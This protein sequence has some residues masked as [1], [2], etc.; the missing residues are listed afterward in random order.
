ME[1]VSGRLFSN[2]TGHKTIPFLRAV[3]AKPTRRPKDTE[4]EEFQQEYDIV[5]N[6]SRRNEATAPQ[7]EATTQPNEATHQ[8]RTPGHVW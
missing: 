7:D 2:P 3:G 8:Q 4:I 1:K 6:G 5:A